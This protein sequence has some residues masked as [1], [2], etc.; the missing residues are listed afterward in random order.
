L[1]FAAPR[2]GRPKRRSPRAP[3]SS[4]SASASTATNLYDLLTV[5]DPSKNYLGADPDHVRLLLGKED[6][7]RPSKP[8]T[9][10]NILAAVRWLASNARRDDLVIFAYFG[11]GASLGERGD[12]TC[13]LASDST[14]AGRDKNAVAAADLAQEFDRLRSRNVAVFL[15]VNFKGFD[16]GKLSVPEPSLGEVP[17]K[18]FLGD[19]KT[20]EHNPLPGRV[21]YLATNGMS[22]SPDLKDHNVFA[23]AVL[24][25]LKGSAD[26]EGYE[27]DG[28][29]TVD[30]LTEF[31]NKKIPELKRQH[32]LNDKQG[33]RE[34][35]IV[36]GR[37]SHFALT[38][39]PKASA[40]ARARL[41]KFDRLARGL[42][43]EK[44][45]E[46]RRLLERMPRLEGLRKLR[47]EY[48]KLVDG[49]I[50]AEQFDR[51]RQA[52]LE[53]MRLSPR[54]ARNFASKVLE[55]AQVVDEEYVKEVNRGDMVAGA[56]RGLYRWIDEKLPEDVAERLD[57]AKEM[58]D[59]Q[60]GQ[61]LYDVR[62]LLGNREDLD[63]HKD[64]DIA[65]QRMLARLDP[66]TTYIDPETVERFKTDYKGEFTGIGV[67]IRKDSATD[68][69]QIVTPIKGS[70]SH[71]EGLL[72]GDLIT[73]ITREVDSE[74]NRLDK[75]EVLATKDL[76]LSDAV[77]KIL[78]KAGT[79]VTLTIQR[80]GQ[81]RPIEVTITRTRIELESVFGVKRKQDDS[82][83]Y[84]LDEDSK[85][86]YV[87]LSNFA[88]NTTRELE[89]V[90]RDLRRQGMRGL[91]LDLRFNPGGLLNAAH[92]IA[93]LFIDE[94]PIVSIRR[95]RRGQEDQMTGRSAGSELDFKMVCLVNTYS[96]SASEIVSACLQDH[97]RAVI[98]GERSYGKGSVQNI[99]DFDGGQIKVTIASFWRPSG[100]NLNKPATGGKDGEEWGVKPDKGFALELSRKERDDL[101]EHLR[102]IEII[103]RRDRPAKEKT[104]F[105]DRQL[106]MALKYLRDQ[107]RAASR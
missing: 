57:Q 18:E 66:Y 14:L 11:Q 8:A 98:M 96:A 20:E 45:E 10:A 71:K 42:G 61:L 97:S 44:A 100:K 78:G 75:P 103:P 84:W 52:V 58:R 79:K 7:T 91:V 102:N 50:T 23:R 83:G 6:K 1:C 92:R 25:G 59:A 38:S 60:L 64:I 28:L 99:Q 104:E 40:R 53:S 32:N 24:D 85:I 3:T 36:G 80:E 54:L 81:Q 9:R 31:V 51:A 87:R 74:G 29:V 76:A 2:C 5:K 82:W 55:A 107:V 94:G 30:E 86:G 17:Y 70:P 88:R 19:D 35:F 72:A 22:T 90:V 43:R 13:Y 47:K 106:D 93:D 15:D 27:P 39:N 4:S 65:L 41:E 12:R 101:H 68:M 33:R 105:K 26:K 21:I 46:G 34:H 62:L 63:K 67:Q 69:L 73:T 49:D 89:E 16:A 77:K 37:S 56:V 48:Q 95:P